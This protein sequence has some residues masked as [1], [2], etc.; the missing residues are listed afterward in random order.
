MFKIF[1]F[2]NNLYHFLVMFSFIA[3]DNIIRES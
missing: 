2:Q 1:N 3:A